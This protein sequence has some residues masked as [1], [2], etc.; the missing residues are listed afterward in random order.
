MHKA[1]A[2]LTSKGG[3]TSCC[4]GSQRPGENA[5]SLDVLISVSTMNLSPPNQA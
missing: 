5:V 3:M 4:T 1:Q 2:I